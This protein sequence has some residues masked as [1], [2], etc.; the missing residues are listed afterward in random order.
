MRFT[1]DRDRFSKALN[2][3]SRCVGIKTPLP[4]Y[5][6]IRLELNEEGLHLTASNSETSICTLIPYFVQ[7]KEIISN[8]AHGSTLLKGKYLI[9]IV[10]KTAM[11]EL[12]LEVTV[13]NMTKIKDG[14]A[15]F[16]LN[17]NFA[18]EY[19]DI[20]FSL[21]EQYITLR[22]KDFNSMIEKTAF[23]AS[24]KQQRPILTA[25]N[26]VSEEGV[27][28]ATATDASRL[29]SVSLP[30]KEVVDFVANIPANSLLD[31]VRLLEN[32]EE[33]LVDVHT[34][35][36]VFGF[37]QTKFITKL[38]SGEYPNTKNVKPKSFAYHL[39]VN[40]QELIN[41][42]ERVSLLSDERFNVVK[43]SL[44]E[45]EIEV[46][47]RTSEIGSASEKIDT[48]S[49]SGERFDIS[50]NADFVI[51]AV[52]VLKSDDVSISF[53]GEMKPFVVKVVGDEEV[54]QVITPVRS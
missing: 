39:Q 34:N 22:A 9:D 29:A 53:V 31:V 47:S 30:L 28:V 25:V 10:R 11:K 49:Y 44:S 37:G 27:L 46:S 7:D 13:D 26:L 52:K 19:P 18:R 45:D 38:I 24:N 17:S 16:S 23:A 42:M 33:V 40:A 6:Y 20:D 32:E 54:I 43:L 15:S 8:Y 2:I 4:I 14:K 35:K 5:T 3:V 50:F 12:T 36:V 41:A 21:S 1:I 51:T 48:F